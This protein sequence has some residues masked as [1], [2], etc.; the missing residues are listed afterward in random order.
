MR[1]GSK[2]IFHLEGNSLA[3]SIKCLL[4][5]LLVA[6]IWP[7]LISLVGI[8]VFSPIIYYLNVNMP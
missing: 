5:C 4:L 2:A 7:L 6:C 3:P 8:I 1:L